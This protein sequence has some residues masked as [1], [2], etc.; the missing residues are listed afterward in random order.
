MNGSEEA[1]NAGFFH[2]ANTEVLLIGLA[3]LLSACLLRTRVEGDGWIRWYM[4]T[5]VYNHFFVHAGR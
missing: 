4:P 5:T 2:V 3:L 1:Y